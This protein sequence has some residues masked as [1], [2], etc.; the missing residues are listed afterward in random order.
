MK[1]P[2]PKG[3][4]AILAL[5]VPLGLAAAG[6]FAFT[7]MSGA[8]AAPPPVP[9][10][11]AGQIGPVLALDDKVINLSTLSAGGYKYAKIGVSIELRPSEVGFY[12]LHGKERTTSETTELANYTDAVPLLVDAVGSVVSSHESSTLTTADGRDKLKGELL[13]AFKEI[14]GNDTVIR[15]L[16][17]DFVMQ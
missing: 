16:F 15:V 14:L 3:R 5:G 17:T 12:D 9:D 11:G 8:T 7:Q 2:I 1:L 13:A 10:P 4:R 6:A